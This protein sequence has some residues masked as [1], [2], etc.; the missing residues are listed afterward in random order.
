MV[1]SKLGPPAIGNATLIQKQVFEELL[2]YQLRLDNEKAD[3]CEQMY[4]EIFELMPEVYRIT[5][6]LVV[7]EA[8]EEGEGEDVPGIKLND[9]LKDKMSLLFGRFVSTPLVWGENW[10]D[11]EGEDNVSEFFVGWKND[12]HH[13]SS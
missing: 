9:V 8:V 12:L 13:Q 11:E 3:D 2:L 5:Q 4:E 6:L 1:F 10:K 7:L